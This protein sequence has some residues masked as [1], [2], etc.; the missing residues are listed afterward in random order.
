MV[1]TQIQLP[2]DVFAKATKLCEAREIS[3]DELVRRGIESM[4]SVYAKEHGNADEWQPPKPRN[5]GWM[6]LS[7]EEIKEQ[8]Q[9]TTTEQTQSND[10]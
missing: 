2:D 4:L 8:A 1:R 5:L 7:D 6:G 10:K 3:F 9:L